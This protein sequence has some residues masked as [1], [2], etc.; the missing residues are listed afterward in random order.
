MNDLTDFLLRTY[1]EEGSEK[2]RVLREELFWSGIR[3]SLYKKI[4][5]GK[6]CRYQWA[7]ITGKINRRRDGSLITLSKENLAHLEHIVDYLNSEEGLDN[8]SDY[9][10]YGA[11]PQDPD[12]LKSFIAGAMTDR[13]I[14]REI[15]RLFLKHRNK[16]LDFLEG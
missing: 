7:Y 8:M 1:G 3:A 16:I 13:Q 5:K 10:I 11:S 4:N 12:D 6:D 14:K 9:G 15:F 2:D